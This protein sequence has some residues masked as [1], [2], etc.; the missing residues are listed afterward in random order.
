M[1]ASRKNL[2]VIRSCLGIGFTT[3]L[4][5]LPSIAQAQINVL[6]VDCTP[7]VSPPNTSFGPPNTMGM[8][9][10][11]VDLGGQF[12]VTEVTPATFRGLTAASLSEFDVIAVN[13]NPSRID[14]GSGLG[15]GTTWHDVIG[16]E[17]GGRV[18]LTSHDAA[19]FKIIITPGTSF[20]GRGAPGPGVEP[21]GADELVRNTVAWAG[22]G[23]ATGLVIFNDSARFFTV[24]GVGWDNPELNLPAA[25]GITDL[26]QTGGTPRDGGYTDILPAFATHPI[27]LG[28][29]DAR[30][31]VNS[32]S[33]FPANVADGSFHSVFG[34][35]NPAIFTATEV[36]INA[37]VVDVGG[38]NAKFAIGANQG[39]AGPDGSAITLVRDEPA[40][41]L[42]HFVCYKVRERSHLEPGPVMLED[43]FN[44]GSAWVHKAKS[45]CVPVD[46][47]GEGIED[48]DSHLTCYELEPRESA[49]VDVLVE[50]QFGMQELRVRRSKTL[51]VPSTKEVVRVLPD[52]DHH[53][54]GHHDDHHGDHHDDHHGGH[55]G[56]HHG[57]HHD[58][59]HDDRHHDHH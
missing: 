49:R 42:D 19:R 45:L 44:S 56:D 18:V 48:A 53:H 17:S 12:N 25:W 4:W 28:V 13:N 31:G 22:S 37:G 10:Q 24:G 16:V 54:G 57:G 6:T 59:H 8:S 11:Q 27:Y 34:S 41:R 51:C 40:P 23:E 7:F 1:K 3:L 15:L 47:N 14:C 55:H 39:P 30:F 38:F 5:L 35:F 26:D 36:V 33:S 21:F 52:K 58:D 20:F 50:N 29:S 2:R 32:L 46:K 43:Q 9:V